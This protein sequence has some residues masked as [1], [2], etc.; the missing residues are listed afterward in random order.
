MTSRGHDSAGAVRPKMTGRIREAALPLRK[1]PDPTDY[2]EHATA[3]G[4]RIFVARWVIR[5]ARQLERSHRPDE[6]AALLFGR[7]FT[8]GVRPCAQVTDLI[9]PEAG[10]VVG[11]PS[12][13]EITT[14]GKQQM[15]ARADHVAPCAD[16]LGWLHS[17]PEFAAFFSGTDQAEQRAWADPT[18]VGIV[19]SGRA[20]ADPWYRVFVGPEATPADPVSGSRSRRLAPVSAELPE[21]LVDRA[22]TREPE[23]S[24]LPSAADARSPRTIY[25]IVASALVLVS[26]GV[27]VLAWQAADSARDAALEVR[28]QVRADRKADERRPTRGASPRRTARRGARPDGTPPSSSPPRTGGPT[29]T[30][31]SLSEDDIPPLSDPFGRPSQ[32]GEGA[33]SPPTRAPVR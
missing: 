10:E 25:A 27:S 17:H 28:D 33:P 24:G 4:R 8:D 26:L 11:T 16:P 29:I 7:R 21:L 18:S 15:Q 13:V 12:T 23:W 14:H 19:V 5:D 2:V 1:V 3:D 32:E 20:D 9:G 22:G 30:P 6:T 31:P